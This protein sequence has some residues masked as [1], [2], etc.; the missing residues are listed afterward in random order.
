M[1]VSGRFEYWLRQEVLGPVVRLLGPAIYWTAFL[2]RRL[3]FRTTFVAV[4]GSLGKTTTKELLAGILALQGPVFRTYRNQNSTGAVALNVLRVRPWHR[5]A[6]LEVAAAAPNAM[7][8]SARLVSPGA[9]V[10]LNVLKTHSTEYG[11][12][13]QHAAEKAVLLQWVRPSGFAVLNADDPLV[14]PMAAS[15][16]VRVIRAGTAGDCDYQAS[17]VSSR[18]PGRLSF[19][20]RH[21]DLTVRTATQLVGAHWQPST[22]AA[23]A[24]AHA[25]GVPLDQAAHAASLTPPFP[26]RLQPVQVPSGAVILRDDYNASIDTIGTSVRVLQDAQ[27]AR[28]LLVITG[29][30]DFGGNRKQGLKYLAGL[31]P[32]AVEVL[33]LVGESA[34]Y[35]RRRAIEQGLP[36]DQVHAFDSLRGA[37]EFL[38]NELRPGDLMLLKGRTTDHAARLF[39]AQ[40]GD[41]ACWKPYCPKR[42]LCDICW[43][44]A[45]TPA[46]MR[47]ASLVPPPGAPP[48]TA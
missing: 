33:V 18:W 14:R 45:I 25:L 47:L 42:M 2:W 27:A 1:I 15:C 36:E 28:R 35:G 38:R 39:F 19:N 8:R 5:F 21:R 48:P 20:I 32:R 37:A 46:Q 43:E 9:A 3:L 44:L 16:P 22:L 7:R 23:I 29:L 6:V 41:P 10:I 40:L 11:S 30:S 24:A 12:L 31:S 17:D 34:G 26:G 13:E 4:T